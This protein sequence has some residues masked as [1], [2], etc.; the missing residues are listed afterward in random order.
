M[1]QNV[2]NPYRYVVAEP[3]ISWEQTTS[4]DGVQCSALPITETQKIGQTITNN[5]LIVGTE[6][7]K[8]IF[9]LRNVFSSTLTY[10]I[11][12][13]VWNSAGTVRTTSETE[14]YLNELETGSS[15][16]DPADRVSFEFDSPV[17]IAQDDVFGVEPVGGVFNTSSII[18]RAN[19]P[20]VLANTQ[21]ID[22]RNGGWGTVSFSHWDAW[23]IAYEPA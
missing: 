12:C 13:R 21:M 18:F 3:V 9:R 23:L 14:V 6:L 4:N 5:S 22:Y 17:T 7:K 20:S 10:R 16:S 15:W 1:S 2:V 19:T 8:I 11:N